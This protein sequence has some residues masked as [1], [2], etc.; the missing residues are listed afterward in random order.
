MIEFFYPSRIGYF[1]YSIGVNPTIPIIILAIYISYWIYKFNKKKRQQD[2][3]LR[4]KQQETLAESQKL[5]AQKEKEEKHQKELE[6]YQKVLKESYFI[7]TQIDAGDITP[8]TLKDIQQLIDQGELSLSS[9]IKFG[10]NTTKF[11]EIQT[12]KEFTGKFNNFM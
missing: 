3:F 11:K 8:H 12:F 6:E 7:E 1:F 9:K 2:E 4:K 5:Q 10:Y